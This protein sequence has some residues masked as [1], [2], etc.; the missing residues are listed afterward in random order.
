MSGAPKRGGE[1]AVTGSSN[2]WCLCLPAHSV[3]PA[4]RAPT[5]SAIS[6]SSSAL[7]CR[8]STICPACSCSTTRV[9]SSPD[10]SSAGA[11]VDWAASFTSSAVATS[12]SASCDARARRC[13]LCCWASSR[14]TAVL[15]ATACAF[16]NVALRRSACSRS[17]C[18]SSCEAGAASP[19]A[20]PVA[21]SMDSRRH[22][23]RSSARASEANGSSSS[24]SSSEPSAAAS[25]AA[26]SA[27]DTGACSK[28]DRRSS[29]ARRAAS[30]SSS[31]RLA[32]SVSLADASGWSHT[33]R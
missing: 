5:C 6:A 25:S 7:R 9:I 21:T 28:A 16:A 8:S 24:S 26:A 22:N 32:I 18:R 13:I 3:P 1:R 23:R 17:S 33:C 11:C 30:V 31:L 12:C 14:S 15:S 27:R 29:T 10:R 4:S 2:P 19:A 20:A